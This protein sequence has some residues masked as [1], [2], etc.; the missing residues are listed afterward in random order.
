MQRAPAVVPDHPEMFTL[1]CTLAAILVLKIPT[2]MLR[3]GTSTHLDGKVLILT[4]RLS[5]HYCR[6]IAE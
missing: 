5:K 4:Q 2:I 1:S 3:A 6:I